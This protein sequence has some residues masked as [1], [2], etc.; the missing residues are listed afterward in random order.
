MIFFVILFCI[1]SLYVLVMAIFPSHSTIGSLSLGST[2]PHFVLLTIAFLCCFAFYIA[3][4]FYIA[5]FAFHT[6]FSFLCLAFFLLLCSSS[7][8]L[9]FSKLCLCLCACLFELFFL[10]FSIVSLHVF[11]FCVPT[12]ALFF[13]LTFELFCASL[14]PNDATK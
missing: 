10:C 6:R 7:Y 14:T 12:L 9:S 2:S 3:C 11:A 1:F 4:M 8:F 5:H 13:S